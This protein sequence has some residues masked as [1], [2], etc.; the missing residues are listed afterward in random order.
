MGIPS[1]LDFD[2]HLAKI[3]LKS[4][5]GNDVPECDEDS[6]APTGLLSELALRPDDPT[7]PFC[8]KSDPLQDSKVLKNILI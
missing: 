6:L 3:Y 7:A 5:P 2:F 8:H 1:S 4:S